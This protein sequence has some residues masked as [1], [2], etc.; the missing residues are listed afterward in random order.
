MCRG[1]K[2]EVAASMFCDIW[3]LPA[4]TVLRWVFPRRRYGDGG[5]D[6]V[7]IAARGHGAH[8]EPVVAVGAVVAEQPGDAGAPFELADVDQIQVQAAVAV[9]VA[10]GGRRGRSRRRWR[11][12][13]RAAG[14]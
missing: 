2:S 10:V 11:R 9:E 3:L 4:V 14:R 12:W 6:T 13:T 1:A 7:A 8:D 5:A